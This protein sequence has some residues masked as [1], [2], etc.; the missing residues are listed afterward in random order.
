LLFIPW[1]SINKFM[2]FK[3]FLENSEEYSSDIKKTLGKIP[4][5]H[6]N[7]IKGYKVKFEPE[8]TL[9]NDSGHV[10]FIDEE[11]KII[12]IAAPWNYSRS[13]TFLHEVAHAVWKYKMSSAQKKEWSDLLK[14]TKENQKKNISSKSKNSLNQNSEEVFCMAYASKYSKHPVVTYDNKK[15]ISFI[16]KI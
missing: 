12:R 2:N 11:K 3:L 6:A 5:D 14:S 9:K 7:L 15:W 13:F 8:N 1:R 16:G 4:K 10:G